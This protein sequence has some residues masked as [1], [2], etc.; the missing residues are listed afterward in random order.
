M[1]APAALFL[2]GKQSRG[3][4]RPPANFGQAERWHGR[5][6]L[7]SRPA[8]GTGQAGHASAK[9]ALAPPRPSPPSNPRQGM[10]TGPGRA[11]GA[12]GRWRETVTATRWP[13]PAPMPA[14]PSVTFRG[15]PGTPCR[16]RDSGPRVP[17]SSPPLPL[18]R[19][20]VQVRAAA[21]IRAGCCRCMILSSHRTR[22]GGHMACDVSASYAA[23]SHRIQG[24]GI[25]L[26]AS[27]HPLRSRA[28]SDLPARSRE[29]IGRT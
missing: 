29:I 20:S 9:L 11:T 7:P 1:R 8:F 14:A 21:G 3:P 5:Q 26:S 23:A 28:T 25:H 18:R 15:R 17:W 10:K 27:R 24:G 13:V 16:G 19:V 6:L 2:R 12:G 4:V 22:V